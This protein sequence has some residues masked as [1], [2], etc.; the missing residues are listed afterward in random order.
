MCPA[1]ERQRYIVTL[2]LIG[3]MHT[4]KDPCTY[5]IIT[6]EK[7][8]SYS[9]MSDLFL[10]WFTPLVTCMTVKQV[11]EV[12]RLTLIHSRYK[13]FHPQ[14]KLTPK[15]RNLIF[16]NMKTDKFALIYHFS[17]LRAGNWNLSWWK[18]TTCSPHIRQFHG[19]CCWCLG[20]ARSQGISS[21]GTDKDCPEYSAFNTSRINSLRPDSHTNSNL[22]KGFQYFMRQI[23]I[24]Y[25]SFNSIAPRKCG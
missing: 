11:T 15:V 24:P 7:L 9:Q 6:I 5:D 12:N 21:H 8:H 20:D 10:D 22:W 17:I 25:T 3:W 18:S 13:A 19:C 1:S 4:Q 14:N 23:I 2:S 16:G